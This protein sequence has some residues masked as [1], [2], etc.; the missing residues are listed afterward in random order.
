M[1]RIHAGIQYTIRNILGNK[2]VLELNG[3]D[4]LLVLVDATYDNLI[5]KDKNITM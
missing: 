1:S 3:T 4:Q 5:E 2:E